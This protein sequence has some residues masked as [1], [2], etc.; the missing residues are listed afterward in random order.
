[1]DLRVYAQ[2]AGAVY[3]KIDPEIITARGFEAIRIIIG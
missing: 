1:M 2:K 3:I